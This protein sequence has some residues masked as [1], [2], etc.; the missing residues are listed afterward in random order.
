MKSL[1]QQATPANTA[2]NRAQRRDV[3]FSR[4]QDSAP[5][6]H[7]AIRKWQVLEI[8]PVSEAQLYKEMADGLF[9]PGFQLTPGGRAVAWWQDEVEA[10]VE[11]RAA[12]PREGK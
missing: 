1:K 6:R 5:S 9:P 11:K 2:H 7:R 10:L 3:Q 12:A 8:Y 4:V